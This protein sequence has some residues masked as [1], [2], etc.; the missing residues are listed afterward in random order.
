M[1]EIKITKKNK[2]HTGNVMDFLYRIQETEIVEILPELN[3]Y[4]YFLDQDLY[5]D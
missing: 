3:Q 4:N 1:K 5:Y 2:E